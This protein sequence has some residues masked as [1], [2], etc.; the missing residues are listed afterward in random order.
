MDLGEF[1]PLLSTLVLP[2]AGP[3]LLVAL[4][5][6]RAWP[7]KKQRSLA[8]ARLGAALA[9]LGVLLLW[10]LSCNA[11]ALWLSRHALPQVQAL[12]A[13]PALALRQA[14]VQAI[15]VL[16][17]GVRP[18]AREYGQAQPSQATEARLRYGLHLARASQ[19]PLGFAGGVGWGA[20]G[21]AEHPPEADVA[22]RY[23]QQAGL[24]I[25]WLDDRSRDTAEN[26]QQMARLLQA[27]GIRRI[28]L[29][30]HAWH[31]PRAIGHFERAGFE[32]LPAPMGFLEPQGRALLEWLPSGEGLNESRRILREWLGLRLS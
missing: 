9:L 16:G 31:L 27:Q 28:A 30:T 5:L 25:R 17:G 23:A 15:V 26:A 14:G 13:E 3:L 18:E 1:K 8:A 11:V 32:V 24:R 12:P 19:L 22:E 20:S 2:P 21:M 7:R 4:G 6:L 10:L 29:V